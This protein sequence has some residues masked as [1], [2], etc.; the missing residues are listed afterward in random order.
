[1]A[2]NHHAVHM[3][4]RA[5][6]IPV[7]PAMRERENVAFTPTEGVQFVEEDYV[8]ATTTLLGL[9]RGGTV[10]VTALYVLRWY[11]PA[12]TGVKALND[13]ITALLALFEPG[14]GITASDG[15]IVRVRGDIGPSRSQITNP[16][17]GWAVSTIAIPVRILHQ[18]A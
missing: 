5:R 3:A 2:V 13:G 18:S 10:E 15:T 16:T 7:L 6:A 12:G 1:M 17:P 14:T 4:L 9:V 8:P 11:V